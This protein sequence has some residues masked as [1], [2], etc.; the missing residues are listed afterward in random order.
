MPANGP[1]IPQGGGRRGARKNNH[2]VNAGNC[3]AY[4]GK[5]KGKTILNHRYNTGIG[6]YGNGHIIGPK[7]VNT[8]ILRSHLE[9]S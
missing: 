5:H 4:I 1:A 8:V 6:F 2:S 7:L 3:V 9:N